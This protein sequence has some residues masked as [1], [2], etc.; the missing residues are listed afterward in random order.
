MTTLLTSRREVVVVP[1]IDLDASQELIARITDRAFDLL[2]GGSEGDRR[3]AL[4]RVSDR[5]CVIAG[6][7]TAAQQ[8]EKLEAMRAKRREAHQPLVFADDELAADAAWRTE[9]FGVPRMVPAVEAAPSPKH[10][11]VYCSQCGRGFGPGNHGF[12]HCSSH[13]GL[14]VIEE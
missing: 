4:L 8:A 12:S 10:P 1:V 9:P 2:P 13:K 6:I 3:G 7:P 11:M 5:L 14:K